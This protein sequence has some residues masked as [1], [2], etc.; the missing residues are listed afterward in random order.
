MQESNQSASRHKTRAATKHNST[1]LERITQT[2]QNK[3]NL[4][5]TSK[6][7]LVF[8]NITQYYRRFKNEAYVM[9]F[10]KPR[11]NVTNITNGEMAAKREIMARP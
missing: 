8:I 1:G 4:K 9:Q 10:T 5:H 11:K 3:T 7:A 6:F 2:K